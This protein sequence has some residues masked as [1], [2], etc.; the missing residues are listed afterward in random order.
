MVWYEIVRYV[1]HRMVSHGVVINLKFSVL[2]VTMVYVSET[3]GVVTM[4]MTAEM[5]Q[6]NISVVTNHV[7]LVSSLV[8]MDIV[9]L[10][11]INATMIE[12]VLTVWMRRTA[13]QLRYYAGTEIIK[14]RFFTE[15]RIVRSKPIRS[16]G[17]KHAFITRWRRAS[18]E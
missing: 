12:I 15:S 8:E 3:R 17:L 13:N 7:S 11:N 10:G 14:R 6:T 5:D 1:C 9:L 18:F 16:H 2:D 4:L